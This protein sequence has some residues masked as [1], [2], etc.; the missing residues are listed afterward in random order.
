MQNQPMPRRA[1]RVP[2]RGLI[3]RDSKT[4]PLF[5]LLSEATERRRGNYL[6]QLRH[7]QTPDQAL[8]GATLFAAWTMANGDY[9]GMRATDVFI[10]ITAAFKPIYTD[11]I[12]RLY[13]E[14]RGGR[15]ITPTT[16]P[17][18]QALIDD[19]LDIATLLRNPSSGSSSS[20]QR[21]LTKRC[22][23]RSMMKDEL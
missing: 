5:P 7:Y 13:D 4:D 19:G 11:F 20:V 8:V 6:F 9:L 18:L 15:H 17:P 2:R 16:P 3:C 22:S 14:V 1:S 12:T 10:E 23:S 21:N